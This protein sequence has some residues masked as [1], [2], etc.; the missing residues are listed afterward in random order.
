MK[1][2]IAY[3]AICIAVLTAILPGQGISELHKIPALIHH[4]K[5]HQET[6]GHGQLSFSDFLAMHYNQNSAH[7]QEEDHEDLPLFHTCCVNILFVSETIQIVLNATISEP[8]LQPKEVKN[9]YNYSLHHT[10]FQPPRKQFS[11]C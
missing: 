4:Y 11:Y 2:R 7:K 8:S 1:K 6:P 3:I 9:E 10:I 5:H